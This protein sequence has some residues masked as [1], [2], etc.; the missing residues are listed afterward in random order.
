MEV[1]CCLSHCKKNRADLLRSHQQRMSGARARWQVSLLGRLRLGGP[2]GWSLG[3][4][5]AVYAC[6]AASAVLY[7]D[8]K[9]AFIF[10]PNVSSACCLLVCMCSCLLPLPCVAAL[11]GASVGPQVGIRFAARMRGQV[12]LPLVLQP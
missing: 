4:S 2:G 10:L 9:A 7:P 12:A 3:A 5:G 1:T 6:F 8:R 11:P